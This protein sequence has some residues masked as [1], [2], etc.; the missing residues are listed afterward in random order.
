MREIGSALSP[1]GR[2][3]AFAAW[4]QRTARNSG[5]YTRMIEQLRN[6]TRHAA[7]IERIGIEIACDD[8]RSFAREAAASALIVD[9]IS[10]A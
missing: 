4:D 8:E 10:G 1:R 9:Q 2:R 7:A 5:V 6:R 3:S